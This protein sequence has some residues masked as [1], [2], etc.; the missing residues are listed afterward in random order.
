MD[1]LYP[2]SVATAESTAAGSCLVAH[3]K[4]LLRAVTQRH[5]RARLH[6]L[7]RL[8]DHDH[9]ELTRHP[10]E[11]AATGEGERGT[12]HR[13]FVGDGRKAARDRRSA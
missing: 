11:H 7:R 3:Q 5:Q 10:R 1:W 8:V 9:V 4:H 13:G 2:C 6:R 12:H